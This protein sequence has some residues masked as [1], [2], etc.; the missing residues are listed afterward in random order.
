MEIIKK[1]M[2]KCLS[3]ARLGAEWLNKLVCGVVEAA[4]TESYV[5]TI[6][7]SQI[8]TL[9][10]EIKLTIKKNSCTNMNLLFDGLSL[11]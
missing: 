7:P 6:S 2:N 1:F 11:S 9:H 3:L 5:E 4:R 8:D 10:K